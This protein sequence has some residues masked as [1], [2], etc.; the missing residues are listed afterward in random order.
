M[1]TTTDVFVIVYLRKNDEQIFLSKHIRK[2][3]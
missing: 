1:N 2:Q 3:N